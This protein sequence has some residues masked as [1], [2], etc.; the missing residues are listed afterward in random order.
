MNWSL[1]DNT[2]VRVRVSPFASCIARTICTSCASIQHPL[3]TFR[4]ELHRSSATDTLPLVLCLSAFLNTGV[5]Y[6]IRVTTCAVVC[7]ENAFHDELEV[8]TMNNTL[9]ATSVPVNSTRVVVGVD[10]II[11]QVSN[12]MWNSAGDVVLKV[13]HQENS[14][15]VECVRR[16]VSSSGSRPTLLEYN[17]W[18]TEH[19]TVV[20]FCFRI[21]IHDFSCDSGLNCF[22]D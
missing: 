6:V 11:N 19:L 8:V 1:T 13:L 9:F 18:S 12:L 3:V 10:N 20:R 5:R 22:S 17:M 2:N 15:E 21:A 14:V 4:A 7:T 16:T